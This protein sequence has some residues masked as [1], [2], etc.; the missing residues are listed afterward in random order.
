MISGI[1]YIECVLSKFADH[2][3]LSG[4]VNIVEKGDAIQSDLDMLKNRPHMIL[5]RFNKAYKRERDQ[6]ILSDNDRTG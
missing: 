4:A 5:I 6:L 3:K 1:N 2:N